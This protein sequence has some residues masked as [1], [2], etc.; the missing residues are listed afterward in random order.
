MHLSYSI[1]ARYV[2][3]SNILSLSLPQ[4]FYIF[5]KYNPEFESFR[6]GIQKCHKTIRDAVKNEKL[7]RFKGRSILFQI[8][9]SAQ[10]V[11]AE[12]AGEIGV[13]KKKGNSLKGILTNIAKTSCDTT[14]ERSRSG[15]K[16][17]DVEKMKEIGDILNDERPGY[18]VEEAKQQQKEKTEEIKKKRNKMDLKKAAKKVGNK[19][20]HTRAKAKESLTQ[21]MMKAQLRGN[22][23]DEKEKE[24][25]REKKRKEMEKKQEERRKKQEMLQKKKAKSKFGNDRLI[26]D[27][28]FLMGL[29]EGGVGGGHL[30]PS[31][32]EDVACEAQE[33]LEFLNTR[34]KF[35][36]QV[37]LGQLDKLEKNKD[38]N[39]R[40]GAVESFRWI[41]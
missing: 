8:L 31:L 10:E 20:P 32:V 15:S 41:M 26:A 12:A 21:F 35:W 29:A 14:P 28:V 25:E 17:F 6:L 22:D 1:E 27:K 5:Q 33:A 2:G 9:T 3:I 34:E 11:Q 4:Q 36:D 23:A 13:I 37:D 40:P 7:F 39:Q 38:K 30:N 16:A 18:D 24:Q 19:D